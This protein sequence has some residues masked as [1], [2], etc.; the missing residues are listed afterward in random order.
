[1]SYSLI[2]SCIATLYSIQLNAQIRLWTGG[3]G[4]DNLSWKNPANWKDNNI[5]QA[6]DTA[7]LDNSYVTTSYTVN[8]PSGGGTSAAR[9]TVKNLTITPATGK[10]IDCVLPSGNTDATAFKAG[11]IGGTGYGLIINNGGTF[12]NFSAA[13]SGTPVN[14]FDSVRINNGG[15]YVHSTLLSADNIVSKLSTKSGTENGIFEFDVPQTTSFSIPVINMVYGNLTLSTS[16]STRIYAAQTTLGP[17]I[18]RGNLTIKTNAILEITPT[19]FS[20][21][22]MGN[23]ENTGILNPAKAAGNTILKIGGNIIQTT[24]GEITENGAGTAS[25]ELNGTALQNISL[26]GSPPITGDIG[27]IMN[28]PAGAILSAPL[29]LPYKLILQKGQITTSALNLLTLQDNCT[30]TIPTDSTSSVTFINGPMK[31]TG[32]SATNRFLFPVGKNNMHRWLELRNATG[33]FTIEYKRINPHS[34]SSSTTTDINHISGLEYW[35]IKADAS[36]APSALI[37]LSFDNVNS[38]GVSDLSKLLVARLSGGIW[39]TLGKSNTTGTAGTNGSITAFTTVSDFNTTT[40]DF[41]TLANSIS[42]SN[43]LPLKEP[44]QQIRQEAQKNTLFTKLLQVTPSV[45]Q[46]ATTLL[47]VLAEKEESIRIVLFNKMGQPVQIQ[48]FS[49]NKG[50][51]KLMM[52]LSGLSSGIY[53]ITGYTP[54]RATNTIR[55]VKW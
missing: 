34:L 21:T 16:S 15:R 12:K 42:Q 24:P 52:N 3:G 23:F 9:V 8:L 26:A 29:S 13:S 54:N 11:I 31:K 53:Q 17:L 50:N 7:L 41:F 20:I 33:N 6:S 45:I 19:T 35:T 10:T 43:P 49:L 22:I 30:L 47:T 40:G 28:N 1:M 37:K 46:G 2:L 44:V 39:A 51:N 14:I 32:I 18:I 36:P 38:G 48:P 55:L 27:F 5:P 4:P 25:I